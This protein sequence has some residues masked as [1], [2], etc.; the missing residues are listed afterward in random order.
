MRLCAVT[1]T[2][3]KRLAKT[4]RHVRDMNPE[5]IGLTFDGAE[6]VT[7]FIGFIPGASL[8]FDLPIIE[9]ALLPQKDKPEGTIC[10]READGEIQRARN[11]LKF[12]LKDVFKNQ[13]QAAHGVR[14]IE[15]VS[16]I[17]QQINFL[18]ACDLSTFASN[19]TWYNL[20]GAPKVEAKD[21]C[22]PQS[23]T[24]LVLVTDQEL[25]IGQA[26]QMMKWCG[27]KVCHFPDFNHRDSNDAGMVKPIFRM[28]IETIGKCATG[29]FGQG[30]WRKSVC[31]AATML[32]SDTRALKM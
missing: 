24:C 15:H 10:D 20:A 28:V 26:V 13:G 19:A 1:R 22:V 21:V 23:P 7:S 27:L 32:L 5:T 14:A 2:K 6:G 16:T 4:R 25:A 18:F 29:P 12:G 17:E 31:E 8:I 3:T 30:T 11:E 9:K